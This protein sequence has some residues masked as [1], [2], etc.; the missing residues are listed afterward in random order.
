MTQLKH[1]A[2][3]AAQ[4]NN[5]LTRKQKAQR[6]GKILDKLYP[7]PPIP[8]K[9]SSPFTLLIAVLLSAQ[10]T[11]KRVN[12]ITP[13]LFKLARSAKKCPSLKFLRSKKLSDHVGSH[14][15]NQKLFLGFQKFLLNH[16]AAKFQQI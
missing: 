7:E 12:M 4:K 14:R 3:T 15:K 6:I 8:L 11:D 2:N 5:A 13:K 16:M 10:C 1:K 9:H